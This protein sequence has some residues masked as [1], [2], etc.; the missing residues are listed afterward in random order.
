MV[1]AFIMPNKAHWADRGGSTSRTDKGIKRT[2]AKQN[3]L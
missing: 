3:R 2:L 1:P